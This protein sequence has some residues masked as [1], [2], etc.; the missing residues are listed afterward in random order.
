[1][2][3]IGIQF[4]SA[5]K[6]PILPIFNEKCTRT[7]STLTFNQCS[8]CVLLYQR[9]CDRFPMNGNTN[10]TAIDSVIEMDM[11]QSHG[12]SSRMRHYLIHGIQLR[13]MFESKNYF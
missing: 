12:T 8:I 11:C 3:V 4:Q 6:R 7:F 1:M 10:S 13:V 9:F 5:R 2:F